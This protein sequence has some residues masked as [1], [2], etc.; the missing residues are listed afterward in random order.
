MELTRMN[1]ADVP[2]VG[3]VPAQPVNRSKGLKKIPPPVPVSPTV[4]L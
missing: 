4:T 2:D 1:A 3:R